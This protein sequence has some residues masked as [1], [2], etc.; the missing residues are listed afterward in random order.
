VARF[1]AGAYDDDALAAGLIQ[2]YEVRIAAL[3]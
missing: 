1:E 3:E 2:K